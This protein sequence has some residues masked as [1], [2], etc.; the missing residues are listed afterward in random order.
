M[1]LLE[2]VPLFGGCVPSELRRISQLVDE[3]EVPEGRVLIEEGDLGR[4]AFVIVDGEAEA[5]IRDRQVAEL[6]PGD[7]FG[8]MSLLAGTNRTATVTA[9]TPMQ[10]LVLD[11]RSFDALID[12]I[13]AVAKKVLRQLAR[14]VVD[15]ETGTPH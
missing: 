2:G 12:E 9:T 14:R 8:E 13:P 1:L 10:L 6:G 3:I 15:N 11:S 5:E 4:E 7:C